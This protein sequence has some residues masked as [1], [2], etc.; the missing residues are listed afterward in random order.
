VAAILH[1]TTD[2]DTRLLFIQRALRNGDPWSGDLAFPGGRLDPADADERAAAERETREE[3]GLDLHRAHLLGRLDD[4]DASVRPMTVAGFVYAVTDSP[5]P[6]STTASEE[7][8]EAFWVPLADLLDRERQ[9]EQRFVHRRQERR[10]PALDLLGPGRPLL[11]GV[12]YRLVS[13]MTALLGQA[14]PE[15]SA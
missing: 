15:P 12:T 3:V 9:C 10:Y 8:E 1:E 6:P 13:S 7:V 5:R 4:L 2:G 14:L 11:W